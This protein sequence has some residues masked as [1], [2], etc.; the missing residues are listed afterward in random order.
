[1]TEVMPV[2]WLDN[3]FPKHV[4]SEFE[5][6]KKKVLSRLDI[7]FKARIILLYFPPARGA[8]EL[9]LKIADPKSVTFEKYSD[10][11]NI[12]K[13]HNR[14]GGWRDLSLCKES[15]TSML[16]SCFNLVLLLKHFPSVVFLDINRVSNQAALNGGQH[17]IFSQINGIHRAIPSASPR[18]YSHQW[19]DY[20]F[21]DQSEIIPVGLTECA[22]TSKFTRS[23][24]LPSKA[25]GTQYYFRSGRQCP[26]LTH[27]P[28]QWRC[29]FSG[30]FTI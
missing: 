2:D 23:I 19:I 24:S 18:Q 15:W 11:S 1:M 22:D 8:F 13:D 3:G 25:L 6:D 9:C 16:F 12:E 4:P 14:Y 17:D 29:T 5:L 27:R 21:T 10:I 28:Q 26:R 30:G 7:L 20:D